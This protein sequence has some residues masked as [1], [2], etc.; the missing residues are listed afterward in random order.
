M[1][2]SMDIQN[3]SMVSECWVSRDVALPDCGRVLV[4]SPVYPKGDIMRFRII[5]S[6]FVRISADVTHWLSLDDIAPLE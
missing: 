6:Q 2:I 1:T 3:K 4:F 5:D